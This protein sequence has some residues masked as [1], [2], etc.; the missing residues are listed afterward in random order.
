MN[1]RGMAREHVKIATEQL[2]SGKDSFLKYAALELRMAMEA[3]TYDRAVAFKEEFPEEEYNTWQP[4]KVMGVL[5][6]IEPTADK[7]STISFGLEEE[8]GVPAKEMTLLGTETVLNM[9]TLKYHYDALGSF[10][11]I[12]TIK[13]IKEG[14]T[15]N[16]NT[17]RKRCEE[18]KAY[19]DKVLSSPVFNTNFG[20][21]ASI[22]CMQCGQNIRKR[23]PQGKESI[24]VECPKCD[25]SYRLTDA[26]EGKSLIEPKHQ[27]IE[28]A[29]K[30]CTKRILV[31]EKEV[32]LGAR[33]ICPEC[34][35]QN[36]IVFGI[37][38]ESLPNKAN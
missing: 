6:E 36:S 8:Y 11:H 17:L 29:N 38:H 33:W 37:A 28:C 22:N 19:L 7:D 3:I 31:W 13:S 9:K 24:N 32:R 20:V 10:L 15:V 23:I 25:A 2:Q 34:K 12:P 16:F 30:E 5:L 35:G 21:F 26:G 14:K 4:K 1:Y 18:I 27:E